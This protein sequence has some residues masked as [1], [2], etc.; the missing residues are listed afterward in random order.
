MFFNNRP[1]IESNV[2]KRY[3]IDTN[4]KIALFAPTFR[5]GMKSQSFGLD[6]LKLSNAL[7][8]RF[9]GSWVILFRNHNFVKGKQCFPNTIDVSMY[10]DMQD[11]YM[12]LTY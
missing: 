2:R 11:C 8:K 10:D 12:F 3:H 4:S 9:G 6:F 7:T 1:D 5:R